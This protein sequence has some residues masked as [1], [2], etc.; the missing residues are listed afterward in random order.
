M[1]S[2]LKSK[3][4]EFVGPIEHVSTVKENRQSNNFVLNVGFKYDIDALSYL[5]A[6]ELTIKTGTH[7]IRMNPVPTKV[8]QLSI[9][10]MS[11]K[12]HQHPKQ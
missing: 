10:D 5:Q 12:H 9:N 7:K 11:E 6:G 8:F 2:M 1:I 3:L 4:I